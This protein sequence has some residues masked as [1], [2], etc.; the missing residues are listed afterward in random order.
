MTQQIND[1]QVNNLTMQ[2]LLFLPHDALQPGLE[3]NKIF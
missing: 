2:L 1:I 3:K